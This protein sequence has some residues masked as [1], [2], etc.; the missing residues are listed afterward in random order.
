[1]PGAAAALDDARDRAAIGARAGLALAV[2]YG[3]ARSEI[4]EFAV[5]PRVVAQRRAAVADRLLEHIANRRHKPRQR[6]PRH[7]TG[8]LARIDSRAEQ[9]F[10]DVDVAE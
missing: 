2:V 4:A 8:R 6:R 10:A 7:R 5:G 3:E 9:R 1:E